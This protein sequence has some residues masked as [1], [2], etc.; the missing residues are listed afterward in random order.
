MAR[1]AIGMPVYNGQRFIRLAIDSIRNQ[2]YTN[3]QLLIADNS[4]TD[5]TLEICRE[6]EQLDPRIR[7]V[8][9]DRNRGACDNFNFVFQETSSELFKWQAADDMCEP[10]Y[11]ER[12]VDALDRTPS[13]VWAHSGSDKVD[14]NGVSLI[15][16]LPEEDELIEWVDGNRAWKGFPRLEFDHASPARRFLHVLIGTT[17]CVDCFGVIRRSALEKTRLLID[18]YGAEKVMMGELSLL[19]TYAHVPE[20]LF[21]QRIHEEASSAHANLEK[22]LEYAGVKPKSFLATRTGLF[23]A[24]LNSALRH[25]LGFSERCRA[26]AAV[27]RYLFQVRKWSRVVSAMVRNQGVGGGGKELLDRTEK[28]KKEGE[29]DSSPTDDSKMDGLNCKANEREKKAVV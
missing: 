16:F 20:L 11:L 17:W 19:G 14:A 13:A 23:F 7:V 18:T 25:P 26:V 9:R 5:Q 27:F 4:S 21:V 24:H 22:Q 12:C 15:N 1:V 6:Y 10:E 2:T 29:Q 28:F 3:W 8:P